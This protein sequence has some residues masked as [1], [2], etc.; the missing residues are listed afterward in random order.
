MFAVVDVLFADFEFFHHIATGEYQMGDLA[1]TVGS[2]FHAFSQRIGHAHAHAVQSAGEAIGAALAFVEFA[3]SVQT[4]KNDLDDGDFFFRV[5]AKRNASAVV[6][7][8]DRAVAVQRD[9]DFLAVT[10]Q[11]FVGG[12]V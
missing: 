2:H 12:V 9:G 8:A 4:G 7:D 6:F 11:R 1:F 5:H 3:A 10:S